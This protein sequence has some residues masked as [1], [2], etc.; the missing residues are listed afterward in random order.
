MTR[1]GDEIKV[2]MIV[3]GSGAILLIT[4]FLMLHYNPFQVSSDEYRAY[5]RF[6]GGLEN[7]AVV[8]FGGMRRGKVAA[9]H[10]KHGASRPVEVVL[11]VQNGTPVK[12]DSVARVASLNA[13]GE[14]YVEISPGSAN[15]PLLPPGQTIKSEETPEFSELF[16]KFSSLSD[17][18][19]HL[20]TETDKDIG[21]ISKG[22]NTLLANLNEVTGPENR[23]ALSS[24][25]EGANRTIAHADALIIKTSPRIDAIAANLESSTSKIDRMVDRIDEAVTRLNSVLQGVNDTLAEDRPLI[26]Q[27]LQTLQATLSDARKLLNDAS[28]MLDANR[29]DIDAIFEELRH[30]SENLKEF[31]DTIKQRPFSLVRVKAKPDRKLPK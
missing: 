14:N 30:S 5:F 4:I 11:R 24:A 1:R 10:L 3:M 17:D 18:A 21:Q 23:K 7:D 13:L 9:V 6:A 8:R 22:A 20:I 15:S 16:A 29:S 2:G 27:D 28:A 19:K 25:L 26:K 12:A 31:T